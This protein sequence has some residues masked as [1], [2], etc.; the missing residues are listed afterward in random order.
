MKNRR[1]V[2]GILMI[3]ILSVSNIAVMADN[4]EDNQEKEYNKIVSI[5]FDDSGSMSF[6]LR[7]SHANYALQT[8]VG[9]LDEGD[10]LFLNYMN[11]SDK[12]IIWKVTKGDDL[13]GILTQIRDEAYPDFEQGDTPIESIAYGLSRFLPENNPLIEEGVIYENWFILITDGNEMTDAEGNSYVNY[14]QDSSYDSGYKWLGVLDRVIANNIKTAGVDLNTVILKIG[15]PSQ[16]MLINTSMVGSPVIY[17]SASVSEEDIAKKQIV[18]SMIDISSL[19]SGRL[20]VQIVGIEANRLTIDSSV[21]FKELDLL[22]QNSNGNVQAVYDSE[23]NALDIA[24][25]SSAMS[26]P[27]TRTISGRTL[28]TDSSLYGGGIRLQ[29]ESEEALPDGEYVLEF[30][31]NIAEAQFTAFCYPAIQFIFEYYVDGLPVEQVFQEEMVTLEFIPVREGTVEVLD[32]LP[33]N[34]EYILEMKNGDQFISFGDNDLETNPFI[35]KDPLIVGSLTAS[36]P[37]IWFWTLNVA[38]E[39]PLAPEEVGPEER[40]FE[41]EITPTSNSVS[42][43]DFDLAGSVYIIPKLNGERLEQALFEQATIT[44]RALDATGAPS[45][46][47]YTLLPEGTGWRFTPVYT[48]FKPSMPAGVFKFEVRVNSNVFENQSEIAYGE[49]TYEIGDANFLIR[50]INY[51][52]TVVGIVLLGVYLIGLVLKPRLKNKTHCLRIEHYDEIIEIGA[53]TEV[54]EHKIK[55]NGLNR[56]FIP[57]VREVGKAGNFTIKAG[58]S[59]DHVYIDKKSQ[60][61]G[62]V[63]GE[64]MLKFDTIGKRDL[65]WNAEQKIEYVVDD[66]LTIFKYSKK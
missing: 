44:I 1:L 6:D 60:K 10:I 12:D 47:D 41:V 56:L 14:V 25:D 9:L 63:L 33:N 27:E 19:I 13:E 28:E 51:V 46:F 55:V 54:E 35:I 66:K 50:Y 24:I 23:G 11:A 4:G 15:E 7:W 39:I 59:E 64:L 21:P 37:E 2:L 49:F 62:M 20:P 18:N 45:G 53:P 32:D 34:I 48:G 30:N 22:I 57:F 5:V 36:I 16:D 58:R 3:L 40:T 52:L 26:A 17:K 65:R 61:A 43:S 8:M 31:T 38:E 42:Y 29:Y